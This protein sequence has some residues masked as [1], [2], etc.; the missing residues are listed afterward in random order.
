[1]EWSTQEYA[2]NNMLLFLIGLPGSGK[3]TLGKQLAAALK[4]PFMD[5]DQEI[6]QRYKL[7]IEE[8]FQQKGESEFRKME[9]DTLHSL[10]QTKELIVATGGGAACFHD[11]MKW[12]NKHGITLYLNPPLKELT[13]RLA[14]AKNNHRPMLKNFSEEETQLFLTQKYEERHPYYQEAKI[15]I[16]TSSPTLKDILTS[17][18]T[19]GLLPPS[20]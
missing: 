15:Q 13:A 19:E 9:R 5:L 1:M 12:M 20:S 18:T 11:N 8:I 14:H 7:S 10:T 17:L 3:T 2:L 16:N 6:V 4:I